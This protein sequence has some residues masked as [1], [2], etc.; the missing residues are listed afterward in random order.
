MLDA[1][2]D[3]WKPARKAEAPKVDLS[4]L[5]IGASIGFGFVPQ[6]NLSGRRFTVKHINTYQFGEERLTSFLLEGDGNEIVSMI[7]ADAE[8]EK[9][10][11]LSRRI[12]PAMRAR[13]FDTDELDALLTKADVKRLQV[14]E[15]DPGWKQ[16]MVGQYKKEIHNLSGRYIRGDFRNLSRL[17]DDVKPK[18]F[19]YTLLVSDNNEYAIEAERYKDNRLELYA[20]IYRRISDIG[21][22]QHAASQA[23]EES[24]METF[25]PKA[26]VTVPAE[27]VQ[28]ADESSGGEASDISVF[29]PAAEE[30]D[31]AQDMVQD[32]APAMTLPEEPAAPQTRQPQPSQPL[33]ESSPMSIF[34]PA[35]GSA[36][37]KPESMN[38]AVGGATEA[39]PRPKQ[40]NNPS[41]PGQNHRQE[42]KAV[43][44]RNGNGNGAELENDAIE[45]DLR[46][47]NKIIEEAIRNEM[48]LSDV[49]RRIIALPVAYPEAVQIPVT[50]SDADFQLLAI[51]YGMPASNRDAIK[52]RIIEEI[53]DFSGGKK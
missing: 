8:G 31:A 18:D 11:A 16:W 7:V 9:Y 24:D 14:K 28:P 17:P 49:V 37:A 29:E 13:M 19:D 2:T 25:A 53:N 15:Q 3:F 51:R 6:A 50:L 36:N 5:D 42:A 27:A 35:Q 1:I 4:S 48:R 20:T 45:C 39:M 26:V 38:G 10:L 52:T 34:N 33:T 23:T 47:A 12:P 41:A 30:S 21:E 43:S 22:I 40:H 44:P 46:V 32:T